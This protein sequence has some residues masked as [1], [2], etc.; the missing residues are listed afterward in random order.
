MTKVINDIT[1]REATADQITEYLERS[2][3]DIY[4]KLRNPP[5]I[6]HALLEH[7]SDTQGWSTIQ[8]RG[9]HHTVWD[10]WRAGDDLTHL[11]RLHRD[12][13]R[14]GHAPPIIT[15]DN[16]FAGLSVASDPQIDQIPAGL[17]QRLDPEEDAKW[18]FLF[19][20]PDVDIR[21]ES[22]WEDEDEDDA[23]TTTT[24]ILSEAVYSKDVFL[25]YF[26][27]RE[28]PEIPT[29]QRHLDV[30][31][32]LDDPW[33]FSLQ[34]RVTFSNAIATHAKLEVDEEALEKFM[35]LARQHEVAK[36]KHDEARDNVS[37]C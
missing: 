7:S 30:L 17:P 27:L 32:E 35:V 36:K 29:T 16:R 13:E 20:E 11:R 6:V 37:G 19:E 34:E 10:F 4:A 21:G 9:K 28:L 33:K 24:P 23:S 26:G 12:A 25:Q 5:P 8:K 22:E 2:C 31:M 18:S 15:T 14:S 1:R 3:P